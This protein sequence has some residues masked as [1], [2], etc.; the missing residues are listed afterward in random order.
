MRLVDSSVFYSKRDRDKTSVD[1]NMAYKIPAPEAVNF[2][3]ETSETN[4]KVW[5][6]A[7]AQL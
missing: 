2:T 3:E 4:Y 7:A 6:K 5:G 1:L